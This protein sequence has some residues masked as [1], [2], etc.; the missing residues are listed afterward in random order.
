MGEGR[1]SRFFLLGNK[2]AFSLLL[3]FINLGD[4]ENTAQRTIIGTL[5]LGC[6]AY[7]FNRSAEIA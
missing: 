7:G 1:V 6:N 3:L 2:M 4:K 5:Y